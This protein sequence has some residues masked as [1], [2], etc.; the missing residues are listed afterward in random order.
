MWEQ[1]LKK[2]LVEKLGKARKEGGGHLVQP[3]RSSRGETRHRRVSLKE[4][5]LRAT[6]QGIEA[7][8]NIQKSSRAERG[9]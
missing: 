8:C 7:N 4:A 6:G 2:A 3:P 9:G 1:Q 5:K